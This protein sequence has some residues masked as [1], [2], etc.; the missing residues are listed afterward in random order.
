METFKLKP[1]ASSISATHN[2]QTSNNFTCLLV[3]YKSVTYIAI[4][5]HR[6]PNL[7]L[8]K[9]RIENKQA[10]K[11]TLEL[12]ISAEAYHKPPITHRRMIIWIVS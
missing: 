6:R 10:T 11:E 1:I 7:E 2:S 3:L 5:C 8:L 9:L 12:I 4:N